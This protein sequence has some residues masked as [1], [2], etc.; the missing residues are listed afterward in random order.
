MLYDRLHWLWLLLHGWLLLN[1]L[2]LLSLSNPLGL[3]LGDQ[4][5]LWLLLWL[6]H[7]SWRLITRFRF[8]DFVGLNNLPLNGSWSLIG[9][10]HWR[11]G[12]DRSLRL[13]VL[14]PIDSSINY[15]LG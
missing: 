1:K 12:H 8:P 15:L 11:I 13:P 2:P 4:L 14:L 10:L 6:L 5:S 7:Y 9:K 3:G